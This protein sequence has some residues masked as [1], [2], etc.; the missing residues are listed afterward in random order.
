MRDLLT[1]C[2]IMEQCQTN[3]EGQAE[4]PLGG[5]EIA[6]T[7]IGGDT[8]MPDEKSPV[9][10]GFPRKSMCERT[11]PLQPAIVSQDADVRHRS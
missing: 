8:A 9:L 2:H 11:C 4:S 6:P 5:A 3:V 1:A 10:G 7:R